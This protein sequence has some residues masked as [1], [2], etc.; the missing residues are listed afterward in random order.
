MEHDAISE[1]IAEKNPAINIDEDEIENFLLIFHL[2]LEAKEEDTDNTDGVLDIIGTIT[3]RLIKLL[4]DNI[5]SL[6]IA[7]KLKKNTQKDKITYY[8]RRER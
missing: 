2:P 4:Q 3:K 5:D 6:N 1:K 7:D 8:K